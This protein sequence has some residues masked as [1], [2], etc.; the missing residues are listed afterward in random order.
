LDAKLAAVTI[1]TSSTGED[2]A[3]A[4]KTPSKSP[5]LIALG[6]TRAAPT[7][8]PTDEATG[9]PSVIDVNLSDGV[10]TTTKDYANSDAESAKTSTPHSEAP[11]DA[12]LA[13]GAAN[14]SFIVAKC[15]RASCAT[16]GRD[17]CTLLH[18][19]LSTDSARSRTMQRH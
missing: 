10:A 6:K 4:G 9:T 5:T 1:N 14:T 8:P 2:G 18:E 15:Q 12:K 17:P 13:A 16:Y 3:Y 19:R 7:H 11:T